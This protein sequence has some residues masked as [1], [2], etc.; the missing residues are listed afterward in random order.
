MAATS[1]TA[2]RA[3][4]P[5]TVYLVVTGLLALLLSDGF[6]GVAA[7]LF[8][9]YHEVPTG[10]MFRTP[11]RLRFIFMICLIALASGGLDALLR[12][13]GKRFPIALLAALGAALAAVWMLGGPGVG[14]RAAV[15]AALAVALLALPRQSWLRAGTAGAW[16]VFVVADLWLATAPAGVLHA[17]P[18]ELSEQYHAAF[19]KARISAGR[20]AELQA[21]PEFAR[22]ETYGFF[23]FHAAGSAYGLH[24]SACYGPL[25]PGQWRALSEV[26]MPERE[27]RG[28]LANPHPDDTPS[29]YDV[30]AVSTIVR[31]R[32]GVFVDRNEDALPRAYHVAAATRATQHEIFEHIRDGS[33]DFHHGVL[34]EADVPANSGDPSPLTPARIVSHEPERVEI[35][36]P[37]VGDGWLVL[38]DTFYPGWSAHVGGVEVA[39]QRANG[40]YRA[41]PV[42]AGDRLVVFRYQ[43]ESHRIGAVVSLVSLAMIVGIA[44]AGMRMR[45]R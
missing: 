15:A 22:V 25:A 16:V 39:I 21:T 11:E 5:K 42:E 6:L 40:L 9:A 29:F 31:L 35:E 4:S 19:R 26:L 44:V 20:L 8:R 24:R 17:Y 3:R 36:L 43:P 23:P 10:A 38:A 41:V 28:G 13:R 45:N 34:L 2:R 37:D 27:L 7:P 1:H 12:Y 32:R 18:T 30:A 33:F 14:W